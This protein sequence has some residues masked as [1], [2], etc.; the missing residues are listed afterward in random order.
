MCC[1]SQ[2]GC[3]KSE[4][5]RVISMKTVSELVEM[6]DMS[7]KMVGAILDPHTKKHWVEFSTDG[8]PTS[9]EWCKCEMQTNDI[10]WSSTRSKTLTRT[11]S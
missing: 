11:R 9:G 5:E 10:Y 2:N 4:S 1:G 8:K 6:E 3:K 7:L